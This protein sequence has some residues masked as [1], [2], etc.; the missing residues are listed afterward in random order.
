MSIGGY[1]QYKI[2][3][4][5]CMA[6]ICQV[7]SNCQ[8]PSSLCQPDATA[9][10]CGPYQIKE[11]YWADAHAM[12]KSATGTGK[13]VYPIPDVFSVSITTKSINSI[14]Y[15]LTFVVYLDF[16]TCASD[17]TCS[18]NTVQA[19]MAKYAK[20]SLIN[21]TP[22]CETF[23]RIHT[24]GPNGWSCSCTNAYWE[25]VQSCLSSHHQDL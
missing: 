3:P 24:G 9:D 12:P 14:F 11:A 17:M 15:S 4:P 1:G 7:E 10:S 21:H 13:L 8:T 16:Y 22:T 6:C 18:E 23:A 2:V 25:K 5:N 20:A 19:Y